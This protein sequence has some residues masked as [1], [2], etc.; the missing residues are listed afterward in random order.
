ML[1][2]RFPDIHFQGCASGGG[3]FDLGTLFYFPEIWTSDENDPVQRLFIQY[4]TSFA[5]PPCVMGSHVND[6]PV[7]CYRTKAEIALFGS[8][9]FELD[10]RRMSDADVAEVNAVT[11]IYGKFHDDV[12]LEGDLYRLS[13]PYDGR[14][15][16]IDMVDK[17]K[18]K[19]LLLVVGLLKKPRTR[20]FVKL[21]G[22]NPWANYVN[23]FDG[24]V[25]SGDY[26]MKVGIN[27][28]DVR[29]E[30]DSRLITLEEVE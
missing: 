2:T 28:S 15:F 11:E 24:K 19:A 12:V 3:R 22:L 4:G 13:S 29:R 8:Y 23:S 6:D 5:Y 18:S 25:Y 1:T 16:A 27:L 7:T 10:P 21:R 30:F 26:Y 20:R 17:Q 9:G 14:E